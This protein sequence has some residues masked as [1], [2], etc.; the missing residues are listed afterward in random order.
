V[1]DLLNSGAARQRSPNSTRRWPAGQPVIPHGPRIRT[2]GPTAAGT[3]LA[4]RRMNCSP[5]WMTLP[6][7]RL[8]DGG[9]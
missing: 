7:L 5:V 9:S 3:C 4:T 1:V 8:S 2:A 6:G